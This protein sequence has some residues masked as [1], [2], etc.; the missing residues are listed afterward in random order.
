MLRKRSGNR[1]VLCPHCRRRRLRNAVR[2]QYVLRAAE[3]T[4][5]ELVEAVPLGC[6]LC[7][8]GQLWSGIGSMLLRSSAGPVRL[9]LST[10]LLASAKNAF[11][12]LALWF[13]G[14]T[15]WLRDALHE[16][17]ITYREF[18]AGSEL[19]RPRPTLT[20]DQQI[21]LARA[22]LM[23]L[24]T[25][26]VSLGPGSE[27]QWRSLRT[28]LRT[29]FDSQPEVFA[30]A[31]PGERVPDPPT[32]EEVLEA[33]AILRRHAGRA[34]LLLML[35]M[36][37]AVAATG[38]RITAEV[39]ARLADIA[40]HCGLDDDSVEQILAAVA[41]EGPEPQ[42]DLPVFEQFESSDPWIVLGLHRTATTAEARR[43]YL[44]LVREHHPDRHAHL[45]AAFQEAAN[46]RLRK[47]NVAYR[48]LRTAPA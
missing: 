32:T 20:P 47:I 39:R 26:A 4:G 6:R 34:D 48:D 41:E 28:Y 2:V 7:L 19:D 30:A 16:A 33:C 10:V 3:S 43:Q 46:H 8:C 25:V 42:P 17:G 44:E 31:D 24:R 18:L 1:R 12:S 38:G 27:S 15:S 21:E 40:A 9:P 5:P 11:W 13:C 37:L 35:H 45:G 29:F 22:L 23:L 14:P 36:M